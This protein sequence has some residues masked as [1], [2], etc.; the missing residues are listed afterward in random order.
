MGWELHQD[1]EGLGAWPDRGWGPLRS[2]GAILNRLLCSRI[3][4]VNFILNS[5]T[6]A[7]GEGRSGQ[8]ARVAATRRGA[9]AGSLGR[10]PPSVPPLPADLRLPV[11]CRHIP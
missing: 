8:G 2:H 9:D 7:G 10:G 4:I 1:G 5:K 11:T 3:R 6:A